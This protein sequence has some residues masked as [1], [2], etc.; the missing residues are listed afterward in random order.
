ME[1][2]STHLSYFDGLTNESY[3]FNNYR[4]FISFNVYASGITLNGNDSITVNINNHTETLQFD[5]I[6]N[7]YSVKCSGDKMILWGKSKI[8]NEGNPQ[9][10][11][12]ILVDFEHRYKKIKKSVS[13]GVFGIDFIKGKELAYIGTNQG[14]FFDLSSG[15]LKSVVPEFD[16]TGYNNFENC[17]RN[18]S[19]EFN[20]YP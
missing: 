5:T 9:D 1:R 3:C 18:S 17:D 15:N 20:R 11:N 13:E 19:W 6:I 14:L 4:F 10:T 12:V 7:G 2:N 8:I 16:P